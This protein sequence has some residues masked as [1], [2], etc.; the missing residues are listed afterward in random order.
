M[1][2]LDNKVVN[3][4]VSKM[5]H[6]DSLFASWDQPTGSIVMHKKE[7]SRLHHMALQYSE[8][9][10]ELHART[11]HLVTSDALLRPRVHV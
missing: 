11:T 1:F 6:D 9:L 5:I 4:V 10:G 2:A 3:T 7:R 8:N